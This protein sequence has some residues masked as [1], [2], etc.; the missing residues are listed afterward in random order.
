MSDLAH[1][2]FVYFTY[3]MI[4]FRVRTRVSLMAD[5]RMG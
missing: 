2:T 4:R 5:H 3:A 1:D